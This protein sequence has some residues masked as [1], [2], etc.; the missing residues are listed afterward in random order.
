MT[1]RDLYGPFGQY[2]AKHWEGGSAA[3]ELKL[4]KG[5]SFPFSKLEPHQERALRMATGNGV[6][7]KISDQSLGSKPFDSFIVKN[8]EA[9]VVLCFGKS[10]YFIDIGVWDLYRE[11]HRDKKSIT[12]K[13]CQEI[14]TI[15]ASL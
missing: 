5:N 1:E 7:H 3:F 10:A 6:Y 12:L 14:A 9:Y 8:A 4:V 11:T 15:S 2:I 13:T